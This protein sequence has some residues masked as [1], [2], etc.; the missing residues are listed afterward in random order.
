VSQYHKGGVILFTRVSGD[1]PKSGYGVAWGVFS[2]KGD[3]FQEGLLL[4]EEEPM[5]TKA[6]L[7]TE[8]CLPPAWVGS[9]KS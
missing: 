2:M 7:I 8:P 6:A 1:L 5:G 3:P 4:V 9:H